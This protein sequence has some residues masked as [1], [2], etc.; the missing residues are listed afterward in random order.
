MQH[1]LII[2]LVLVF[3]GFFAVQSSGYAQ[4]GLNDYMTSAPVVHD[5]LSVYF[6]RGKDDG[7]S[8]PLALNEAVTRG[9]AT[10]HFSPARE[11]VVDNFSDREIFVQAGDLIMGGLQDQV[12][13]I[14]LIVP[15]KSTGTRIEVFCVE[16]GRSTA[17]EN[18]DAATLAPVRSIIPSDIA[19]L[20]TAT[21][22]SQTDLANQMRQL[23]IWLGVESLRA[24]I[25]D[26]LGKPIASGQSPSSLPL[27]LE[28]ALLGDKMRPYVDALQA[29]PDSDSGILGAIFVINGQR[30][31]AD[32]YSSNALFRQMWPKL[33]RANVIRTIA[34]HSKIYETVPLDGSDM[35]LWNVDKRQ[36]G[37]SIH[38]FYLARSAMQTTALEH[39]ILTSLEDPA[40]NRAQARSDS[41]VL[42]EGFLQ[43]V[44][45][46]D[47][48]QFRQAIQQ[49]L[50]AGLFSS[51]SGLQP[52]I[53]HALAADSL[54]DPRAFSQIIN[55]IDANTKAV[56]NDASL[57]REL[58]M[59]H[60]YAEA[61]R[62]EKAARASRIYRGTVFA[63][64]SAASLS[65]TLLFL[66]KILASRPMSF[67]RWFHGAVVLL[68]RKK[69]KP[70]LSA[71]FSVEI[72]GAD[73]GR[74]PM[75]DES[76]S[77]E[78]V[79]APWRE[80]SG[81]RSRLFWVILNACF[82]WIKSICIGL[83]LRGQPQAGILEGPIRAFLLVPT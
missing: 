14:G 6:V 7:L 59:L 67:A 64:A 69:K 22:S 15:P 13:G 65:L 9:V 1:K 29:I 66:R 82:Q 46:R 40:L 45:N 44:Y 72:S 79:N 50:A 48:T 34:S 56:V 80:R 57:M 36:D 31:T 19:T 12:A 30:V 71:T 74:R 26:Q 17:R 33:L 54:R 21:G 10:V 52:L 83:R 28:N 20:S 62:I 24:R 53:E 37:R 38:K 43:V 58:A 42:L 77:G 18:G 35:M 78:P 32:I 39:A 27:A 23:A 63:L 81:A 70:N 47:Q 11:V 76:R 60:A 68:S 75:N 3:I 8:A 61:Q 4:M 2:K 16:N 55:R 51:E 5:N 41:I 49:A 25:S 73:G